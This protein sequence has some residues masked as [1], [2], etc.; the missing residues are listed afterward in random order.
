MEF[1]WKLRIVKSAKME[2]AM[3]VSLDCNYNVKW[4]F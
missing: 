2:A 4:I 1:L 3:E